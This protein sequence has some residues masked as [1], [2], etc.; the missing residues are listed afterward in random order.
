VTYDL[1][2]EAILEWKLMKDTPSCHFISA[3]ISGKT[4]YRT[5]QKLQLFEARVSEPNELNEFFLW[6]IDLLLEFE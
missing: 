2:K 4:A 6:V 5:N 1:V 3:L